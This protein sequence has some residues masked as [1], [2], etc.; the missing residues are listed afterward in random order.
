M[1]NIFANFRFDIEHI[2]GSKNTVADALSREQVSSTSTEQ[3]VDAETYF[4]DSILQ[5]ELDK[6]KNDINNDDNDEC[7]NNNNNNINNNNDNNNKN[8]IIKNNDDD[9]EEEEVQD[10]EIYI[11]HLETQLEQLFPPIEENWE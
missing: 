9:E 1:G 10:I 7:F 2:K 8:Y 6:D 4:E 3:I 5:M 11:Q